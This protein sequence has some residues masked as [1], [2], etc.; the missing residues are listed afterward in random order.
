MSSQFSLPAWKHLYRSVAQ[1]GLYRSRSDLGWKQFLDS[2]IPFKNQWFQIINLA[3]AEVVEAEGLQRTLGHSDSYANVQDIVN[4]IYG[5]E[6]HHGLWHVVGPT[7]EYSKSGRVNVDTDF[8]TYHHPLQDVNGK[9]HAFRRLTFGTD[10]D[11]NNIPEYFV[12]IYTRLE[13]VQL[14]LQISGSMPPHMRQKMLPLWEKSKP[15]ADIRLTLRERQVLSHLLQGASSPEIAQALTISRHTV[16]TIR[17]NILAK[18]GAKGT[19][20]LVV[21]FAGAGGELL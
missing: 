13:G 12:S 19:A 18:T 7:F 5:P 15:V 11:C 16:D 9:R 10:P 8:F 14:P 20:D 17:R 21:R 1:R 6:L 2:W 3:K 4:Y